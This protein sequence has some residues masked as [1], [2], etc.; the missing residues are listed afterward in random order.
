MCGQM[1]SRLTVDQMV[2]LGFKMFFRDVTPPYRV[3]GLGPSSQRSG[4]ILK[5]HNVKFDPGR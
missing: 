1:Q 4:L 2:K 3:F 5:G